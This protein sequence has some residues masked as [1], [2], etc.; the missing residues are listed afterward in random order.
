MLLAQSFLQWISHG[1]GSQDVPGFGKYFLVV[2]FLLSPWVMYGLQIKNLGLMGKVNKKLC[3][4]TFA[5]KNGSS[6]CR[7]SGEL[8]VHQKCY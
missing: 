5:P 7:G 2:H 3:Q 6:Y 1:H 8:A 4:R